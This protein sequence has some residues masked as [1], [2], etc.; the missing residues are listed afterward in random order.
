MNSPATLAAP[1]TLRVP[2]V[3]LGRDHAELREELAAAF[4]AVVADGGFI[5]G[6]EVEL[7]EHEF[8]A[9]C[10]VEHCVGVASGTAALTVALMAAG[11]GPGDEVIVPAHTYIASALG[12]LHAGATPVLCDVDAGTALICPDS[13]AAAVSSRT[14][15]IMAVHLYGQ[16]CDMRPLRRLADAHGLLLIEDAA[17]AHGARF[18]GARAGGLGAVAAFS[19][20]PSKNLGALGDGGAV[21][22][23]DADIAAAARRLRNLGQRTKGDHVETG[24]NERL[25][26]LQA[27]FLRIKLRQLDDKNAARR[28][29]ADAYRE[30]LDERVALQ[31]VAPEAEPVYHLFS[32]RVED[33]D[34]MLAELSRR[35]VHGGVHYHPALDRQPPLIGSAAAGALPNS[36]SWSEEQ[37]SL[38]MF[39]EL[40][41]DEVDRVVEVLEAVLDDR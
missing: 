36:R 28:S 11:I 29:W 34:R 12:V 19:F 10:G 8:A 16:P 20:Y 24:F 26:G 22:T 14:A 9:Y 31:E 39:P 38:P 5:L 17:Q 37:L 3:D 18:E 21:C 15:A 23:N 7:F 32:I 1:E 33:R 41:A 25:D 30:L 40:T 27:A 6:P 4:D 13:A 2:F 35:G